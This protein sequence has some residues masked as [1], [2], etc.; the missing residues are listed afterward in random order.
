MMGNHGVDTIAIE[1][2]FIRARH[3][4]NALSLL[5]DDAEWQDPLEDVEAPRYRISAVSGAG[6]RQMTVEMGAAV[7]GIRETEE[8]EA[9]EED[10]WDEWDETK[11]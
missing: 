4:V 8:T 6:L 3:Q 7:R 10:V 11:P 1:W 9:R 5:P 2:Q